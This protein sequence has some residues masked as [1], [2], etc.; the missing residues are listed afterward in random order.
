MCLFAGYCK[1]GIIE[2]YVVYYLKSLSKF[3]EIHFLADNNL[4]QQE[5]SKIRSFVKTA[6]AF[7]HQKYDFG[8]WQELINTLG[9]NYIEQFDSL[10]FANDSCYAPVFPFE[11]MFKIMEHS[12]AD[13]WGATVNTMVKLHHLQSY[14]IVFNKKII[15]E[16]AFRHFMNK[17]KQEKTQ[18]D[19]INK[20]EIRLTRL[21]K[22]IGYNYASFVDK[23][24]VATSFYLKL[25][26]NKSPFIKRKAFLGD[27]FVIPP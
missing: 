27:F 17:V 4:P 15:N 9:W 1:N 7:R 12:N 16:T 14:F 5:L 2:D 18:T 6:S 23:N 24:L 20:Y 10:I 26:I 3:C 19:I 13:F 8:S 11:N 22:G 21:L 25:F